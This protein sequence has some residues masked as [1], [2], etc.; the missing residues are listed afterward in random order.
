MTIQANLLRKFLSYDEPTRSK[1]KYSKVLLA[2]TS[3]TQD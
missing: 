1:V 3:D 2:M